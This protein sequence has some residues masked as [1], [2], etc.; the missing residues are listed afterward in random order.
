MQKDSRTQEAE[1]FL[2]QVNDAVTRDCVVKITWTG[3]ADVDLLVEEPSATVCSGRNPR[4]SSGGVMLGD[5]Y[6]HSGGSS[7]DGYSEFYV[8]PK[9]FAGQYRM[10]LKTI[11][12]E[13]TAGK[14][15]VEIWT[16]YGTPE[17]TYLSLIHISEP[18]RPY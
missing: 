4:T 16:N 17:Q 13:V 5:S 18:T 6:A 7:L 3:D 10:L 15:T 12:G 8:C 11:S 9:G 2:A 1:Q 14:V